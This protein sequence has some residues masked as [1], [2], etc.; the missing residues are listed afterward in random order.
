MLDLYD[1][2]PDLTG[3]DVDVAP[4]IRDAEDTDIRVFWRDFDASAGPEDQ[5]APTAG[6]ALCGSDWPSPGL[7]QG[8]SCKIKG[9]RVFH[10]DPQATSQREGQ[11]PCVVRVQGIPLAGLGPIGFKQA[12]GGYAP[13]TGFDQSNQEAAVEPVER[14]AGMVG[15][16]RVE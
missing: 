15:S 6:R 9:Q 12:A 4:Y 3:F 14:Q 5:P 10:I 13:E 2:D 11:D 1:T 7:A 16:R 8:L